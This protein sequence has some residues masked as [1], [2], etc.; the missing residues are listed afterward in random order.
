[1]AGRA[2]GTLTLNVEGADLKI[3]DVVVGAF[4]KSAGNVIVVGTP[5]LRADFPLPAEPLGVYIPL[6]ATPSSDIDPS[7]VPRVVGFGYG[8]VTQGA[9]LVTIDKYGGRVAAINA[10]AA[11]L[12]DTTIPE[13]LKKW[14]GERVSELQADA[15]RPH[16]LLAPALVR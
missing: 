2:M 16:L 12:V 15:L 10:S 7:G 6:R 9:S 13:A 8:K 11:V 5:M 1:M 3:G 4:H 14:F